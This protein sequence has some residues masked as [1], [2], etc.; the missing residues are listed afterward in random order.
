MSAACLFRF[1]K[2]YTHTI[3]VHWMSASWNQNKRTFIFVWN[4]F[5][6][7]LR[8]I[9]CVRYVCEFKTNFLCYDANP[10]IGE[11]LV[12]LFHDLSTNIYIRKQNRLLSVCT[13]KWVSFLHIHHHATWRTLW[14]SLWKPLNLI[15]Y[16]AH[17][18]SSCSRSQSPVQL[19]YYAKTTHRK[20]KYRNSLI[21]KQCSK[22]KQWNI[23]LRYRRINSFDQ[24]FCDF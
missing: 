13:L 4:F 23:V 21:P 15:H 12:S 5:L 10:G 20:N 9:R 22:I 2:M 18:I 1:E 16:F 14:R 17:F 6:H 19:A 3:F 24:L 8:A 7:N 11:T